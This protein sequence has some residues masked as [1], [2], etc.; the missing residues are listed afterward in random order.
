VQVPVDDEWGP[1]QWL[2]VRLLALVFL[3]F[4]GYPVGELLTG[5]RPAGIV[6]LGLVGLAAWTACYV[7]VIWVATPDPHRLSAPYPLAGLLLIGAALV[8]MLGESWLGGL[9]FYANALLLFELPL[10]YWL[11]SLGSVAV[12][13]VTT[14]LALGGPPGEV[15]NALILIC[16]VGGLQAAFFRQIQDS[17]ALRLARAELARLAV[18]EERVR[19]ARDLHDVL[20]QELTAVSLKAQLAARLVRLDPE[21]AEVESGEVE[22]IA[23]QALDSMRATVSGYRDTSLASEVRT[24]SALLGAVGVATTAAEVPA[25]LP[26]QVE[27]AAAWVVREAVTN[28]VRHAKASHCRIALDRE[29]GRLVVRV[30]DDGVAAGYA[31][32]LSRGTGLA[33]LAERVEALGGVLD[34]GPVDGWFTVRASIPAGGAG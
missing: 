10:R 19:I 15:L 11:W 31:P 4:L 26:A 27:Q 1:R 20:G 30:G 22:R 3:G 23:R 5:H 8:P 16:L 14:A 17:V 28:V 34:A 24:A 12:A 9:A 2:R 29:P 25:G 7:T 33:G 18:A 13:Y 6:A 32:P 21:R